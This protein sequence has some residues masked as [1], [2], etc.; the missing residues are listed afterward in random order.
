M[1]PPSVPRLGVTFGRSRGLSP[2]PS[3]ACWISAGRCSGSNRWRG[4]RRRRRGTGS[5]GSWC[6][7]M[8]RRTTRPARSRA[9]APGPRWRAPMFVTDSAPIRDLSGGPWPA[10]AFPLTPARSRRE[11]EKLRR[12]V[13]R[14]RPAD[15]R[16][17]A[18][19]CSRCQRE[20]VGVRENGCHLPTQLQETEMRPMIRRPKTSDCLPRLGGRKMR[21]FKSQLN[22]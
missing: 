18:W 21:A 6:G 10:D 11:R 15:A 2:I 9:P 22:A 20:R 4:A 3:C 7:L 12:C 16:G 13:D 19:W 5:G 14:A 1:S 8:T 17:S